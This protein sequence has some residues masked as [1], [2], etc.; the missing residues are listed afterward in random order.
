MK[1][2]Y[3][4]APEIQE[5]V[6]TIIST[7]NLRHIRPDRIAC[8]RSRGTST[9]RVIARCH[10]LP[11]IMQIGLKT[12]AFYAIELISEKYDQL[13][14]EEKVKVLIHELMHIPKAFGGGFRHHDYVCQ[15]EVDKMYLQYKRIKNPSARFPFF[16]IK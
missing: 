13:K 10:A 1:F 16:S 12:D 3:T 15:S 8:F 6:N 5:Q 11:K 4:T 14:E 7:L 2:E 9:N